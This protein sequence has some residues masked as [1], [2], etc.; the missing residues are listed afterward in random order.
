M[1]E[2]PLKASPWI[3]RDG[4]AHRREAVAY[5]PLAALD[6]S[7][8]HEQ[9][10]IALER[11][12]DGDTLS[13]LGGVRLLTIRLKTG[14]TAEQAYALAERMAGVVE[15]FEA[16]HDDPLGGGAVLQFRRVA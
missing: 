10:V 14:T 3:D 13:G 8:A 11:P 9:W 7:A 16:I 5:R 15:C 12:A 2:V 6:D 4:L 1:M